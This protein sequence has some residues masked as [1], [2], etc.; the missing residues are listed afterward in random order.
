MSQGAKPRRLTITIAFVPA[1]RTL[2]SA[3]QVSGC[4]AP[5]RGSA[6]RMSSTRTGGIGRPSTRRGSSSRG[7]SSQD[8]GRG[9]AV[10]ATQHRAALGGAA[11]GDRAGVVAGV[12]LLLV[13]GVV[14][15]VDHDQAEVA[16]RREDGRARPD[17]DARLAAAQPLP[18]VV[19]LAVGE[20]RVQDGE[21][22]AEPGPEARHRLRRQADLGDQHDRPL[23][24]RQR[25]LD[26]GEVDL[27]LARAGDAVQQLLARRGSGFSVERGDDALDRGLLLGQQLA[28]GRRGRRPPGGWSG[29]A[30]ASCGSRSGR[31]ARAGAARHGRSR[32]PPASSGADI[33]PARS[34]SSTP[35]CLTP[36]R[37]PPLSASSPATVISARS[38]CRERTRCPAA[39]V[40][41]GSTSC[42]PR[43]GVEQYSSAI[44]RPSRTSSGGVPGLQRFDRLGE[45]LG[46]QRR[47]IG[48]ADDD[49][50]H[51]APTEGNLD[52]AAD[53]E[54]G[55][56]LGQPVVE[57]PAQGAG[58]G[59]RLDLRYRH[60]EHRMEGRGRRGYAAR[61]WRSTS[62]RGAGDLPGPPLLASDPRLLP[63]GHPDRGDRRRRSSSSSARATAR[64]S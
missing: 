38:S 45:P 7:S 54:V 55:H 35:R 6:S 26:R 37:S 46:R 57:G 14:L 60:F 49:A 10:P 29:A 32:P 44:Q 31:A 59:E 16:Q 64:S 48:Q 24:P 18:L 61:R 4:R 1:A 50:E 25:R 22:V 21:A 33:S 63:E 17:A 20:G 13:G 39:P 2:S 43:D 3:A 8:S 40:P 5:E 51:A 19:A 52:H 23:A 15:L 9:V 42:S 62:A 53:L 58:G 12:A 30:P 47:G 41:G 27:G 11:A 34:A 28:A 56:R 36:S